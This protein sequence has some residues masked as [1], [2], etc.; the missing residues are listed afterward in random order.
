MAVGCAGPVAGAGGGGPFRLN[1]VRKNVG[2]LLKHAAEREPDHFQALVPAAQFP[3]VPADQLQV[4]QPQGDPIMVRIGSPACG[5]LG[6]PHIGMTQLLRKDALGQ[7]PE[8]LRGLRSA[9][10]QANN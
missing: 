10:A 9:F 7:H 2:Q 8:V 5:E 3:G 1:A 6:R 4:L